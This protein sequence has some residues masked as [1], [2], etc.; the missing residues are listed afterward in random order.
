MIVVRILV[1][2]ALVYF[3]YRVVVHFGIV[4]GGIGRSSAGFQ[5]GAC[6]HCGQVFDDGVMCRF[7]GKETFKNEVHIANCHTFERRA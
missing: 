1:L 2:A 7:A 3:I 4:G 6:R 5:C